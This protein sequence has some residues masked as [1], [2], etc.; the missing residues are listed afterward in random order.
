MLVDLVAHE[1]ETSP[2]KRIETIRVEC[3]GRPGSIVCPADDTKANGW[4]HETN[5]HEG[6]L[7]VAIIAGAALLS[8]KDTPCVYHRKKITSVP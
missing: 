5:K 3:G 2:V 1:R 8:R 4:L 6:R 7:L